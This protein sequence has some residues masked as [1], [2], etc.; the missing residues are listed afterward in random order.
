MLKVPIRTR[1]S[2]EQLRRNEVRE[3]PETIVGTP[4]DRLDDGLHA[5]RVRS[6]RTSEV[7][8]GQQAQRDRHYQ[9]D[10]RDVQ[11]AHDDL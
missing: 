9:R 2:L 11:R 10:H 8:R 5:F 4:V 6:T 7:D 3:E 1:R